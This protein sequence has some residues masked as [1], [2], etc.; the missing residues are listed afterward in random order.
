MIMIMMMAVNLEPGC[1]SPLFTW[2]S[3]NRQAADAAVTVELL[4][5]PSHGILSSSHSVRVRW[6]YPRTGPSTRLVQHRLR[7]VV[8]GVLNPNGVSSFAMVSESGT[9][10][11]IA[12]LKYVSVRFCASWFTVFIIN[13][14]FPCGCPPVDLYPIVSEVALAPILQW[15][16]PRGPVFC[17]STGFIVSGNSS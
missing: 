2:A 5:W 7:Y 9:V 6:R 10:G 8:A 3:N 4:H 1:E 15:E 12:N 14:S 17:P 13:R 16:L 11:F